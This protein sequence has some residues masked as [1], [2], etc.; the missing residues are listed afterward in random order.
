MT[1]LIVKTP[2]VEENPF[3]VVKATVIENQKPV[4]VELAAA[5]LF[6][7]LDL[8]GRSLFVSLLY[9]FFGFSRFL[10]KIRHYYCYYK[11]C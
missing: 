1:A 7:L 4:F 9:L 11:I 6:Y 10:S 3:V 2:L 8:L 5:S